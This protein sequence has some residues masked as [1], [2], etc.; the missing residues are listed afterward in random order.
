MRY[1]I[2]ILCALAA[3]SAYSQSPPAAEPYNDAAPKLKAG[4]LL[5]TWVGTGPAIRIDGTFTATALNLGDWKKGDVVISGIVNGQH[6]WI[7]VLRW[8]SDLDLKAAVK[9]IRAP[10]VQVSQKATPFNRVTT[11]PG[12]TVRYADGS[13]W[14]YPGARATGNIFT[15]VPSMGL[16]GG[17]NCS[18]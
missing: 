13:N 11:I 18:T 1:A 6:E 7:K 14:S 16:F 8:P 5:V 4:Q 12:T 10:K 3:N 9:E 2:L 15:N 17:T